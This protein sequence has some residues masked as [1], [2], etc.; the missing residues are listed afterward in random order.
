[1][2]EKAPKDNSSEAIDQSSE[3]HVIDMQDF[4]LLDY[5]K[6]AIDAKQKGIDSQVVA[7][8][9]AIKSHLDT[10][11][12]DG[13]I[14]PAGAANRAEQLE[15]IIEGTSLDSEATPKAN[16]QQSSEYSS[17]N[18]ADKAEL[19]QHVADE[20]AKIRDKY[21]YDT[22]YEEYQ[23]EYS[24]LRADLMRDG[25]ITAEEADE[26]LA[27]ADTEEDRR[28]E[29][30]D[31]TEDE[32]VR[33]GAPEN[34]PS[35]D[36]LE[37]NKGKLGWRKRAMDVIKRPNAYVGLAVYK[38]YDFMSRRQENAAK[39]AARQPDESEAAYEKRKIRTGRIA[40]LA[41]VA[42]GLVVIG[43]KT[44]GFGLY[45]GNGEGS[46][47]ASLKGGA[48]G[49]DVQNDKQ[50]TGAG[51]GNGDYSNV[52][53]SENGHTP[54][55]F[56][57]TTDPFDETNKSGVHN[58]GDALDANPA[59]IKGIAGTNELKD[60]WANSA[61][62]LSTAGAEM[63][64]DGFSTD[65]LEGVAGKLES[66]PEFA[67][68]SHAQLLEI[69]NSPSTKISQG[70]LEPGTYG[71]Y[72]QVDVN[73]DLVNAYDDTVNE[74]GT[75]IKIEWQDKNGVWREVEFKKECGGQVIHRHP[76]AEVVAQPTFITSNQEGGQGGGS[77]ETQPPTETYPPT[78][79][80]PETQP[81]VTQP[82]VTQP[83]ETQPPVTQPPETQPPVTQ[84][85]QTNAPKEWD[86]SEP[87]EEGAPLAES[88]ILAPPAQKETDPV[89]VD[90]KP[91]EAIDNQNQVGGTAN[92]AETTTTQE[93]Q[94]QQET[95]P[96]PGAVDGGTETTLFGA[97][98]RA[99]DKTAESDTTNTSGAK[100]ATSSD[101]PAAPAN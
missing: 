41:T 53:G 87:H 84:P 80:P 93:Q 48:V 71:S 45:D 88:G 81:P 26:L 42:I 46:S 28:Y 78:T 1:M 30:N 64:L 36:E 83:P 32:P 72:Y 68:K 15:R 63:G 9:E 24:R 54:F 22:Q 21:D 12:A 77:V 74:P 20:V 18:D 8:K 97:N 94:Q 27:A 79:Q 90:Q 47:T 96:A 98:S 50:D 66:N 59:D 73:G 91:G 11:V 3:Q 52:P 65:N 2:S 95:K 14:T 62:Q 99:A 33:N 82:P 56:N 76:V 100:P 23:A 89:V 58:Y 7:A 43:A 61:N 55:E 70:T 31:S 67:S 10:L 69:L 25:G 38:A 35:T 57:R 6:V 51:N 37:E 4:K 40:T 16:E 44:R 39:K 60:S 49:H 101:G 85:P 34:V 13:Q 17:L 92:G 86:G 5:A 75:T 29:D 19:V